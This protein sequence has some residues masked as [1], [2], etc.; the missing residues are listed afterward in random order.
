MMS[1]IL[2]SK[3]VSDS[4]WFKVLFFMYVQ[5]GAQWVLAICPRKQCE[6][7]IPYLVLRCSFLSCIS[8]V[9]WSANPSAKSEGPVCVDMSLDACR[10]YPQATPSSE[11]SPNKNKFQFLPLWYVKLTSLVVHSDGELILHL[12]E[13]VLSSLNLPS[14]LYPFFTPNTLKAKTSQQGLGLSCPVLSTHPAPWSVTCPFHPQMKN[15]SRDVCSPGSL[16][17]P[18]PQNCWPTPLLLWG[19]LDHSSAPSGETTLFSTPRTP[20]WRL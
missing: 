19:I 20:H 18:A 5:S 1:L 8:S 12:G 10:P 16:P 9:P 2:R 15:Q 11:A 17:T 7:R 6:P 4:M 14:Q 13:D 3:V